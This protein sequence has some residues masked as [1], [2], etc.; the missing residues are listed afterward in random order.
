M[1]QRALEYLAHEKRTIYTDSRYAFSVVHTFKKIWE[2]RGLL[3]SKGK[4]LVHEGL[5]LE[6]LEALK[7][8]EEIAVVHVKGY[9]S[10]MITEI[11]ENNLAD[12]EA[13]DAAKNGAKK[14]M[15]ILTPNKEKLEIPKFSKKKEKGIRQ[16]RGRARS[17]WKMETP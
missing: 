6:V 10:G 7:L 9:Q 1:T 14:V 11:R 4:G 2:E 16:D 17:I 12:Q 15:L 13:K 8:P 5:I 3:N